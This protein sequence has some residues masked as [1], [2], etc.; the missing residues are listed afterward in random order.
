MKRVTRIDRELTTRLI[1]E[2]LP[3]LPELARRLCQS[4][5]V[6]VT[7]CQCG[8][9]NYRDRVLRVPSWVFN[10]RVNFCGKGWIDGGLPFAAYYLAHELAHVEA[11]IHN[12]GPAFM[13][14]FKKLCPPPLQRYESIYKPKLAARAEQGVLK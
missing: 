6:A 10:Q 3:M 13:A 11:A 2:V 5:S 4:V 1:S 7:R 12:H 8:R 14:A 9:A